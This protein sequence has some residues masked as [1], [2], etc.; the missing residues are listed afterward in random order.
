MSKNSQQKE[1]RH[2]VI[3]KPKLG[4]ARKLRGTCNIEQEDMN[5]EELREKRKKK[6]KVI[7][8]SGIPCKLRK[9]PG[10]TSLKAAFGPDETN[11]DDG[12]EKFYAP[13]TQER[14]KL[15]VHA[16]VNPA[17]L[18]ESARRRGPKQRVREDHTA[19][20]RSNSLSHKN[21]AH[22]LVPFAP[23]N[24]NPGRKSCSRQKGVW[25][26]L[27]ECQAQKEVT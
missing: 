15:C 18:W 17:G 6:L 3:D 26:K 7:V 11:A 24:E 16:F 4:N 14:R 13:P 21:L 2:W 9:M 10:R 5:I 8:D 19:G 20:R 25:E 22:K 23:C 12:K 27:K 1:K